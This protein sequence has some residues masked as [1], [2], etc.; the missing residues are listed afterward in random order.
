MATIDYSIL[1]VSDIDASVE[2]YNHL[3]EIR[4]YE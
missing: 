1:N 4:T 2:F 3:I